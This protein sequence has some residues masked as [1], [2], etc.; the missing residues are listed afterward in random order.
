MDVTVSPTLENFVPK[1]VVEGHVKKDAGK[2]RQLNQD[3]DVACNSPSSRP[4][5]DSA[6]PRGE[7][8]QLLIKKFSF[9]FP[10]DVGCNIVSNVSRFSY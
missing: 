9:S 5:L 1:F 6:H 8:V 3:M 7:S 10:T 4:C 2:M